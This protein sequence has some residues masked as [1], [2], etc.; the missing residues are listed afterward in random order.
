MWRSSSEA[1][2][3]VFWMREKGLCGRLQLI[4]TQFISLAVCSTPLKPMRGCYMPWY[5]RLP[6]L[7]LASASAP[8]LMIYC[9]RLSP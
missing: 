6:A 8:L 7:F 4:I 3:T 9:P 2:A 5:V 1:P